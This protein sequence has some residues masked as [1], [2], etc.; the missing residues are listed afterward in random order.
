MSTCPGLTIPVGNSHESTRLA[1][2]SSYLPNTRALPLQGRNYISFVLGL[3][4]PFSRGHVHIRSS[5]PFDSPIIDPR[6]LNNGTDIELFIDAVKLVRKVVNARCVKSA[7]VRETAPGPAVQFDAEIVEYLKGNVQTI[8]HPVGT[9]P[10]FPR[11]DGGVVDESLKVYGTQNLRVVRSQFMTNSS[12]DLTCSG[13]CLG[14]SPSNL[15]TY[16][17]HHIR[18]CREGV[19]GFS[20]D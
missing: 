12:T 2:I 13:G 17:A 6:F 1:T 8:Y 18:D 10:M 5:D 19:I 11:E 14:N 9:A 3:L 4:H 16:S 7:I 20:R 15:G